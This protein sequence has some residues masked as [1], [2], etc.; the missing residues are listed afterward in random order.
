MH[1]PV[2]NKKTVENSVRRPG[3]DL[4]ATW[5]RPGGDLAATNRYS[6]GALSKGEGRSERKH[7]VGTCGPPEQGNDSIPLTCR[8]YMD[9]F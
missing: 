9:R 4:A 5:R 3:G 1:I 6:I 7:T 8:P 2:E